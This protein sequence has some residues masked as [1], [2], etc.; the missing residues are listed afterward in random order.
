[1]EIELRVI[2]PGKYWLVY[3][4]KTYLGT[5]VLTD[6]Y[7]AVKNGVLHGQFASLDEVTEFF[8]AKS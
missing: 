8:G 2:T 5:V 1:M 4:G 3:Q 7:K 6:A